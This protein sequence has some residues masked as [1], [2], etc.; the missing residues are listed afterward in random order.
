MYCKDIAKFSIHREI[1]I[2]KK[3]YENKVNEIF[4]HEAIVYRDL[5]K[6]MK[7]SKITLRQWY[8]VDN[9]VCSTTFR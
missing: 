9:G 7:F 1:K 4:I 5:S 6:K 8:M 2:K 3:Y